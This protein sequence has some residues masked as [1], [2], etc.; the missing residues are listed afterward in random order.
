[1]IMVRALQTKTLAKIP[2]KLFSL[3]SE[4]LVDFT[5]GLGRVVS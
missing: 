1:L 5:P 4:R 3:V 2:P